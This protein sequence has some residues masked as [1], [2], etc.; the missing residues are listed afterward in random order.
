[1]HWGIW[2]GLLVLFLIAEA[3]TVSMT[4]LW[5]AIGALAALIASAAGGELWLQ[6]TLFLA[7]SALLLVLLRP[8]AKRYFTPKLIRTN[9]DA[10]IGKTGRVTVTIDNVG[11]QGQVKLEGQVWTARSESGEQISE[12]SLVN[13]CRVEGVKVFVTPVKETAKVE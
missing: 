1:M 4:T 9:V 7:V 10:V 12:G 11:G 2:L 5:F 6:I 3:S 13:V 8:V